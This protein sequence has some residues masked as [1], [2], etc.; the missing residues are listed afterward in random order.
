MVLLDLVVT[1]RFH[2]LVVVEEGVIMEEVAVAI[3]LLVAEDLPTV[4]AA[5]VRLLYT[6]LLVLMA[7]EVL[8]FHFQQFS[9]PPRH[10]MPQR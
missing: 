10:L 9:L 2:T 6:P 5:N 7:M 8:Q 4:M 3:G 1:A